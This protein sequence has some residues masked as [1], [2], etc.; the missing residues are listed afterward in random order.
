MNNILPSTTNTIGIWGFGVTGKAHAHFFSERGNRIIVMDTAAAPGVDRIQSTAESIKNFLEECDIVIPS[1]GID[2]GNYTNYF[3]KFLF[4]ADLFRALWHKPIIAITGTIGKTSTTH[5]LS[6]ALKIAGKNVATGGNIGTALINLLPLQEKSDLAV[7]ELSS[8][9][10]EYVRSFAPELAIITNLFPNHLDRHKTFENYCTAKFNIIARQHAHQQALIPSSLTNK[11]TRERIFFHG[12][13]GYCFDPSGNIV[14]AQKLI[15]AAENIPTTSYRANWL[16]IAAALDL[17]DINPSTV[18]S[19]NNH[20]EIPD[21]RGALVATING[22]AFYN[23]SKSTIIEA[24][25]AAVHKLYPQRII[26]LLGGISKGVDRTPALRQLKDHVVHII[27]FGKEADILAAACAHHA[28]AHSAVTT[29]EDA[30]LLS[31]KIALS[32]DC[33]VLSPGGAS[34]DL[35]TDYQERG[36]IFEKLV[37]IRTP[38]DM[39]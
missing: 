6:E 30:V 8:F 9:Q 16:V 11:I 5:L 23:D 26:L 17:L 27:C 33:V 39:A 1:A 37:N 19:E 32:G 24:T 22:V 31:K 25:I 28:I 15:L 14:T 29:L 34:F 18:F 4:E 2:L 35:F 21:H 36:R 7:I 13:V 12:E 20:F 10:L 38:F 3:H